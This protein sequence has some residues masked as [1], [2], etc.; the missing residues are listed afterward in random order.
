MTLDEKE[1]QILQDPSLLPM[2]ARVCE[3]YEEQL[4]SLWNQYGEMLIGLK[5]TSF[6]EILGAK[7]KISKGENYMQQAY[8]VLDYPSMLTRYDMLLFRTMMLWGDAFSWHFILA[9]K[10][11]DRF[12]DR[13]CL[14]KYRI[15]KGG[16]LSCHDDPWVWH[17]NDKGWLPLDQMEY[18][19]LTEESAKRKFL[20]FSH[21]MDLEEY[22]RLKERSLEILNAYMRIILL[23]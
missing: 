15:P 9:G 3:K 8:R 14:N 4:D 7:G 18:D 5:S 13:V 11:L 23:P 19:E 10:Y 16:Y 1:L 6:R 20:K 17:R 22:P 21:F 2:K 12:R